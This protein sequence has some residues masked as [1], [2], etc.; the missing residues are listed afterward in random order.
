[1]GR[2]VES[3]PIGLKGGLNTYAYV[4]S[5]PLDNADPYGLQ[6]FAPPLPVPLPTPGQTPGLDPQPMPGWSLPEIEPRDWLYELFS[7]RSIP[8]PAKPACGCTC[9]CRADANDNIPGNVKPGDIAFAFGHA[10]DDSCAKASKEAKRIATR[11]FG[12]QPKHVGCRC[13]GS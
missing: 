7:D 8:R 4:N 9:I 11:N 13:V 12:K 1:V 5:R 6:G 3:D 2:Y 10:T